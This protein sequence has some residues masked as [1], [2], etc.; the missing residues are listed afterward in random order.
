MS[1]QLT[2]HIRVGSDT[3]QDM[4]GGSGASYNIVLSEL[5]LVNGPAD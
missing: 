5:P 2:R 3:D 4:T 1:G